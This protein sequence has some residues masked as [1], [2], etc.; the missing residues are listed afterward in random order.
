MLVLA[1]VLILPWADDEQMACSTAV[2]AFCGWMITVGKAVVVDGDHGEAVIHTSDDNL[3]FARRDAGTDE[4]CALG[5][6]VEAA[7]FLFAKT[8][9]ILFMAYHR[10]A[11]PLC[12][13]GAGA[14]GIASDIADPSGRTAAHTGGHGSG[15][16][17]G[18]D[19]QARLDGGQHLGRDQ[20]GRAFALEVAAQGGRGE[21]VVMAKRCVVSMVRL[22]MRSRRLRGLPW[23]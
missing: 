22:P 21:P 4:N 5:G 3:A 1:P 15:R 13:K 11:A 2:E 12:E 18:R 10:Q 19:E 23:I 20:V 7:L 8:G 16:K 17:T 9:S 14:E 6:L